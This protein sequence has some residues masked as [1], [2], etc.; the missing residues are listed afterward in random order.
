M[1]PME[2]SFTQLIQRVQA[3]DASAQEPLIAMVYQHLHERA[4]R[5]LGRIGG[6][7]VL[8]PT[9]LVNEAWMKML[10][11]G[12]SFRDRAHFLASASTVMRNLLTDR[13]RRRRNRSGSDPSSMVDALVDHY[14][15][16]GPDLLELDLALKK[17]GR[18]DPDAA[19]VV[20]L[21]F[22]VG[23]SAEDAAAAAGLSERTASRRWRFAQ[24]WLKRELTGS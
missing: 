24:R 5:E 8:Q 1:L 15:E 7:T 12:G 13:A 10:A 22:F 11:G 23:A 19:K 20:E 4:Q 9:A 21:R 3:G 14:E 16:G 17:L 18:L 6:D 2:E